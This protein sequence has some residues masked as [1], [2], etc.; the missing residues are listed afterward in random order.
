MYCCAVFVIVLTLPLRLF[1][2]PPL[3]DDKTRL[4]KTT[5]G[6]S[7]TAT[8]DTAGVGAKNPC[9]ALGIKG[10]GAPTRNRFDARVPKGFGLVVSI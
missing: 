10:C 4:F 5:F 2:L 6:N 3:A 1:F 8:T 9:L 7:L